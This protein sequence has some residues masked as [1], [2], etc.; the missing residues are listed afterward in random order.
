MRPIKNVGEEEYDDAHFTED[1]EEIQILNVSPS[2]YNDIVGVKILQGEGVTHDVIPI[3]DEIEKK[4]PTEGT[5]EIVSPSSKN[6]EE[7]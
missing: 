6:K 5:E 1:P 2:D 4:P 3:L 7:D